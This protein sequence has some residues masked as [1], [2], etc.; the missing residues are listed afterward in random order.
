MEEKV[1]NLYIYRPSINPELF[2][3]KEFE[4]I[5]FLTKNFDSMINI[6]STLWWILCEYRA[7][8]N[9]LN[10]NLSKKLSDVFEIHK[11]RQYFH[12]YLVMMAREVVIQL[13]EYGVL[14][15]TANNEIINS[16]KNISDIASKKLRQAHLNNFKNEFPGIREL[17]NSLCHPHEFNSS[18]SK[19]TRNISSEAMVNLGLSLER[20]MGTSV[21]CLMYPKED[22]FG[23][24]STVSG[25]VV[26]LEFSEKTVK[27]LFDITKGYFSIFYGLERDGMATHR[28]NLTSN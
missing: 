23:F 1:K 19:Q 15:F 26:G 7:H 25:N 24:Y 8:R 9:S 21:G 18:L 22:H 5:E 14:I 17:R 10:L 27:T 3:D 11:Y 28:K 6:V 2:S 13:N 4:E 12:N 16:S 20:G